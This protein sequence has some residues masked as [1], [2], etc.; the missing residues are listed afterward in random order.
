M[1]LPLLLVGWRLSRRRDGSAEAPDLLFSLWVLFSPIYAF[2]VVNM[3]YR[4]ESEPLLVPY[5]LITMRVILDRT[6]R[7]KEPVA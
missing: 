1:T 6:R 2:F 5:A 3:R 4:F 7:L